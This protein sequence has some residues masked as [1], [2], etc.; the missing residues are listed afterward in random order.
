MYTNDI[1]FTVKSNLH[2][3]FLEKSLI[4]I[5]LVAPFLFKLNNNLAILND[6]FAAEP[7]SRQPSSPPAQGLLGR[8]ARSHNA[9]LTVQSQNCN[10]L[11]H[12]PKTSTVVTNKTKKLN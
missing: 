2:Y 11:H 9:Q 10:L 1:I 7:G 5:C 12:V 6:V 3:F 8:R 4:L